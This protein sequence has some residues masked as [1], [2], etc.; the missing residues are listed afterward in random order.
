MPYRYRRL[1]LPQPHRMER[2]LA[3]HEAIVEAI[4]GRDDAAAAAAMDRHLDGLR[5]SLAPIRE[6]NP[7]YFSGNVSAVYDRWAVA[8]A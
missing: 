3:E 8:T 2:A 5:T 4:A 1:T 7:D 6:L